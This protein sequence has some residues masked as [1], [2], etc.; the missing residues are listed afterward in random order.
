MLVDRRL[1]IEIGRR[2]ESCL[3]FSFGSEDFG[4]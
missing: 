2:V 1:K 4:G 3:G